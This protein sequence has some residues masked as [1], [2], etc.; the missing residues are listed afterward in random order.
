MG[1]SI[2]CPSPGRIRL[3]VQVGDMPPEA[4]ALA[5][6]Y[7]PELVKLLTQDCRPHNRPEKYIDAPD[8]NRPSWIRTT[9]RVC[10]RFIGYRPTSYPNK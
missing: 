8:P 3:T 9:C 4:V 7:K 5:R 1:V 2:A 6:D 10:G